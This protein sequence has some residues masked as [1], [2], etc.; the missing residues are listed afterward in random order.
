VAFV[1]R[2]NPK[3]GETRVET[4]DL[5]A[6]DPDEASCVLCGCTEYNACPGAC[7]WVDDAADP[8]LE[9]C[10]RCLTFDERRHVRHRCAK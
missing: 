4:V 2:A 7:A 8:D 10:N 3:R 1:P 9:L 6:I 5:R